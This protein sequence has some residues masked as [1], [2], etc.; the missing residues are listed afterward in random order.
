MSLH[1]IRIL[2]LSHILLFLI[3]PQL[4]AQELQYAFNFQPV[5]LR[6]SEL[7][8]NEIMSLLQ[9]SRGFIWVGTKAGLNVFDGYSYTVYKQ[10]SKDSLSLGGDYIKYLYE[11]NT[12]KILIN[13][14][15]TVDV[16]NP[17]TGHFSHVDAKTDT[18]FIYNYNAWVHALQIS[19]QTIYLVSSDELFIYDPSTEIASELDVLRK[20]NYN[21]RIFG[22]YVVCTEDSLGTIWI[23][24]TLQIAGYNHLSK[25]TYYINFENDTNL[26]GGGITNIYC[27]GSNK[28][29][30]FTSEN[31]YIY[32]IT[33]KEL[34]PEICYNLP[35]E[36]SGYNELRMLK[37]D[38]NNVVWFTSTMESRLILF[39]PAIQTFTDKL[40]TNDNGQGFG[41]IRGIF[42]DRQNIWWMGTPNDGL[43]F[44][45]SNN[46]NTFKYI[47]SYAEGAKS[48]NHNS[49]RAITKA[50]DGSIW[51]G[52]DGGGLN[53]Y[54]PYSNTMKI[55]KHDPE[56][57]TSLAS[58]SIL[59]I[60][61]DYYG[62]ILLNFTEFR[63]PISP[64]V[65]RIMSS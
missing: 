40:I 30:I 52:T 63:F 33:T 60:Y 25:S 65:N 62:R 64:C 55:Y 39:D 47:L 5:K 53:V 58:N 13:T 11:D 12:H 54:D 2:I 51:I 35:P 59:T 15:N 31:H 23:S 4:P 14:N 18:S 42:K 34:I 32:N 20:I 22:D 27:R 6:D 10:N 49:V 56:D 8:S 26:K 16:Y 37:Q 9:D 45:Y 36:V 43:L 57:S 38:E 3:A 28:L 44:S 1:S 29:G 21:A 24:T 50:M 7:S 41:Q 17:E 19:D 46:L 48:I 61:Q